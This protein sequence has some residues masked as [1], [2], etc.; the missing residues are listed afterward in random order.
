M[1]SVLMYTTMRLIQQQTVL[2]VHTG[3]LHGFDSG[4]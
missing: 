3:S 1:M 4:V 2:N